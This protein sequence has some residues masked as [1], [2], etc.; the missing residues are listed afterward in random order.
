[1]PRTHRR[2][3]AHLLL[4]LGE[5]EGCVRHRRPPAAAAATPT[6]PVVTRKA[7]TR[8][9]PAALELGGPA[10][11]LKLFGETTLATDQET[12]E[13]VQTRYRVML[14]GPIVQGAAF[15]SA[16]GAIRR[17]DGVRAARQTVRRAP[18]E[19]S[20]RRYQLFGPNVPEPEAAQSW[21]VDQ[22]ALAG[23]VAGTPAA[24]CG[25]PGR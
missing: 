3:L 16:D 10:I 23:A 6:R 17:D 20:E 25:T 9:P 7:A 14:A 8:Q 11:W 4:D 19:V 18:Y 24:T 15:R 22:P 2:S 12:A 1:M 5:P 13:G 21:R